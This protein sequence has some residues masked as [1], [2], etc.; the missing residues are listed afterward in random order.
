MTKQSILSPKTEPYYLA[1][2]YQQWVPNYGETLP[3][4]LPPPPPTCHTLQPPNA[5][6]SPTGSICS[7]PQSSSTHKSFEDTQDND[8]YVPPLP[9]P[10]PFLR[11][12]QEARM[13][14]LQTRPD[15]TV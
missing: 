15:V 1:G 7:D 9:P 10:L 8:D 13:S 14:I 4:L 3:R 5:A 12:Q 2:G 11:N 6:I